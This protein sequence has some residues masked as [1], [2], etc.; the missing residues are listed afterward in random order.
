MV[1]P[2]SK[3]EEMKPK[4]FEDL[5]LSWLHHKFPSLSFMQPDLC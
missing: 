5:N 1:N 3:D 2:I 4:K